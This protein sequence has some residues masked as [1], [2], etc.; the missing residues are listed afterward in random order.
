M[1]MDK[2]NDGVQENILMTMDKGNDGVQ[3]NK[4]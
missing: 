2:G 4:I 3:E 1:T